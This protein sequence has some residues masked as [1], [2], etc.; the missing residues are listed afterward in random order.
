MA[1]SRT[2]KDCI[3]WVLCHM[4]RLARFN[5]YQ[6]YIWYDNVGQDCDHV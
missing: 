3:Q 2:R 6:M 4:H 1:K 5:L